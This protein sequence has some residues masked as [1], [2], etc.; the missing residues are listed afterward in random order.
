MKKTHLI[1]TAAA[2][3]IA[4]AIIFLIVAQN[5]RK[6]VRTDIPNSIY[7]WN[8]RFRIDKNEAQF[9]KRNDIRRMYVRFFDVDLN[10]EDYFHDTC[11]PVADIEFYR[12]DLDLVDSLKVEIVPVVF[13][14]P[15][16]VKAWRS[17]T[18]NLAHRLYA[19]CLYHRISIREVQFDCD[20]T[21][22]SREA[23]FQFLKAVRPVLEGYFQK[24]LLLSST[25][26][27]H[28]LAQAPPEADYGVLMCYNT[29]DFKKFDTQNSILDAKDV[30]PYTKWLKKYRLPLALALPAYSWC[31]E[32][33][34]HKQFV[35][36]NRRSWNAEDTLEFKPVGNNLYERRDAEEWPEDA[37][38]YIRHER[39]PAETNLEAKRLI[40]KK[41]GKTAVILFHLDGHELSKY[42][43]NEIKDFYH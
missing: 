29:G 21:A 30:K 15:E 6:T 28:Q 31:V 10:R 5:T 32:F 24:K 27:L 14:T 17:F 7:Y 26:R 13:I 1:I 2:A 20:W 22:G 33:D 18:D 42:S 9:L 25:I 37:V 41:M 8:T 12:K 43:E 39:V 3:A 4:G 40:Q 19:M 11:A 16:A 35:N 34:G 38:R 23:Y 36:L